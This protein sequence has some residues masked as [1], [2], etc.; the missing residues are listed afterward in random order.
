MGAGREGMEGLARQYRLEYV[1]S[2]QLFHSEG[3]GLSQVAEFVWFWGHN[4]VL[5]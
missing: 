5:F 1:C 2:K 3:A 4:W